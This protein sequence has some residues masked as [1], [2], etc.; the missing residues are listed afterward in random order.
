MHQFCHTC[1][2]FGLF[3][4]VAVLW[5]MPGTHTSAAQSAATKPDVKTTVKR[6]IG[7]LGSRSRRV[8][9]RAEADLIKLGPA[10]LPLLPPP[11]LLPNVSVREAVHRVRVRVEGAAARESIRPSRVT[12]AGSFSIERV[13]AALSRQTGNRVEVAKLP[14]KARD[15]QVAVNYRRATFWAVIDELSRRAGID[16]V[17]MKDEPGLVATSRP[18]GAAKPIAVQTDSAFQVVVRSLQWK[19]LA[20]GS[21]RRLLRIHWELAA[22]PRLRPLFVKFT[23]KSLSVATESGKALAPFDA[24]AKLEFPV[25]GGSPLKLRSDFIVPDAVTVKRFHFGGTLSVLTAAGQQSI[26]FRN[27]GRAKGLAKRRGGVTVTIQNVKQVRL[28]ASSDK[29]RRDR[30]SVQVAVTYDSGGPAF[31]SHRTWIFHNRVSLKLANGSRVAPQPGFT[32]TLQRDGAVG[33]VYDFLVPAGSGLKAEFLY[34]APTLLIDVPVK[35]KFD[36]L[37]APSSRERTTR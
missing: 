19:R 2:L 11:E 34:V 15:K 27:A 12:L 5:S 36:K 30:V 28:K 18:E 23:G 14:Q 24:D 10:I 7:D 37:S 31:E 1:R 21:K 25:P 4:I 29:K 16:F 33:V 13:A 8:R 6:L 35:L 17:P 20:A 3:T 32:T 26:G 22:E 9:A